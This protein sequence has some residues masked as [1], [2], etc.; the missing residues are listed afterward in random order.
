M[1]NDAYFDSVGIPEG[2][3]E[4]IHLKNSSGNTEINIAFESFLFSADYQR[5]SD[6]LIIRGE[7]GRV[8]IIEGYFSSDHP[9][10]LVGPKGQTLYGDV[11]A[12][13]AGPAN[14]G[15]YAQQGNAAGASP[16]GQVEILTGGATVQRTDGTVEPL[17]V[18]SKVFQNDVVQT[19]DGG[20]ISITF[21]DGTVFSLSSDSR[22]VLSEMVFAPESAN[23][24]AV[25]NLVKGTFVF[26][27]GE[28]AK[29][30][31]MNV[32]TPVATMGIR[33]TTVTVEIQTGSDGQATVR[34]A[35]NRDIDGNIGSI[36]FTNTLDGTVTEITK[37]DSSWIINPSDGATREVERSEAEMALDLVVIN[38]AFD[39]IQS[40]ED[41]VEQGE[42]LVEGDE[43][44]GDTAEDGEENED[45]Q[46]T[47]DADDTGDDDAGDGDAEGDDDGD[48]G[49]GDGDDDG[50]T[51][52]GDDDGETVDG[53]DD[54]DV[55]TSEGEDDG[56]AGDGDSDGDTGDDGNDG[57]DNSQSG[58]ADGDD[59]STGDQSGISGSGNDFTQT[60]TTSTIDAIAGLV[61]TLNDITGGLLSGSGSD[62]VDTDTSDGSDDGLADLAPE[63]NSQDN[64][65][66]DDP[67]VVDTTPTIGLPTLT[68]TV[69]EDG[70]ISL[71]DIS[72]GGFSIGGPPDSAA[73]MTLTA[74]STVS[75]PP[76][77]GL[78]IDTLL[79]TE[80]PPGSGK[81]ETLVVSGTISQL[82]AALNGLV[83]EPSADDDDGGS[84]T[85]FITNGTQAALSTL[86]IGIQP[87]E[88]PPVAMDD[89]PIHSE[90][91]AT[92]SNNT[93]T[94]ITGTLFANDFDPDSGD[95][96]TVV[97]MVEQPS[98]NPVT[99]NVPFALTTGA[100]IVF[101]ADGSYALT[102][103]TAYEALGVGDQQQHQFL[104]TIE[105]S[106]GRQDTATLTLTV[107]GNND[108]PT[109]TGET[110]NTTEDTAVN[111]NLFTNAADPD[112]DT[113]TFS[114]GTD[115]GDAP[116]NGTVVVNAN[117]TFTYTPNANFNG[118]D[119][120]SYDVNDGNGG[121]A[122]ATVTVNVSSVSDA[123]EGSDSTIALN[124]DSSHT[125]T[126]ADFGFSDPGDAPPDTFT[127]VKVATLPAN[128]ALTLNGGAIT[129]NQVITVADVSAGNL[130]FTPD[131]N[132]NGVGYASITF[133]VQ[134][135]GTGQNEDLSPNT[136]TFDVNSVND[137]PVLT[138]P[139]SGSELITNGGFE[140]G[141]EG[142][143]GFTLVTAI[144]SVT[145]PGWT[146]ETGDV[147]LYTENS[148]L[149]APDGDHAIDLNGNAPGSV[150]QT[151]TTES[152]KTYLLTFKQ[153]GDP[154][155]GE[156][157]GDINVTAGNANVNL[158]FTEPAG[159]TRA[160]PG[161][162]TH[163]LV[164]TASS[165]STEV[166]FTSLDTTDP[167]AGP[168]LD[169][170][171][172]REVFAG[173]QGTPLEI[174]NFSVADI[175]AG[176]GDV[177][178]NFAAA[179]GT[180][181]VSGT[182]AGGVA[183]SDITNNETA[184]VTLTGTV[185][186][187]NAT[188]AASGGVSYTSNSG[189]SGLD[190]V[191]VTA[192]DLP[193]AGASAAL[194]DVG[195]VDIFVQALNLVSGTVND[196][197][198]INGT[199]GDDLIQGLG[200]T[201]GSFQGD[202]LF[203]LAGDDTLVGENGGSELFDGGDGDDTIV[204][205]TNNVNNGDYILGSLGNDR[206]VLNNASGGYVSFA[207]GNL[208]ATMISIAATI[209]FNTN[210]ASIVKTD[211]T[212][213]PTVVGTDTIEDIN[214]LISNQG[215]DFRGTQLADTFNITGDPNGYVA[216]LGGRGNDVFNLQ[217]GL[218]RL[219]FRVEASGTNFFSQA[220][221][222]ANVDLRLASNQIINDGFGFTDN[223]IFS[224]NF[225]TGS[226]NR[227][228]IRGT[229]FTDTLIGD[230]AD[231]R[232][233]GEQGNDTIDGQGGVDLIR[234]DRSGAIS[235]IV[236]LDAGTATGFWDNTIFNY[237]ISNLEDVRGTN[238]GVDKIFGSSSG[239]NGGANRL[240]GRGG[241][242]VL[243]GRL[244][245]D[246]LVGGDDHNVFMINQNS[247]NDIIEDFV[248]G[249][250]RIVIVE[251]GLAS[252]ASFATFT[253]N[254]SDTFIS[255]D[256]GNTTITVQGVDLVTR[257]G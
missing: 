119:T 75:L 227:V 70:S 249:L 36:I 38:Q 110:V 223:I 14:P 165:T 107:T 72:S 11:V 121:T 196:D 143:G 231:N 109:A 43:T 241:V 1:R 79:S 161:S 101:Q 65:D 191:T 50:D 46:D 152:G 221:Q 103:G 212:G 47:D 245:N 28:V 3:V 99:L 122:S 16:I 76:G 216:V 222:A 248:I 116:S 135:S 164:F 56:D 253:F 82:N 217:S 89:T 149:T 146:V 69:Q 33:G 144:D 95:T 54:S 171:S 150:S 8:V 104:Y 240:E 42:N 198:A 131:A 94:P 136:L 226:G 35:L 200:T 175:D 256:S 138:V 31:D 21:L 252:T 125:L 18:G 81:Y 254:G 140:T 114:A 189:F 192:N 61:D 237:T 30:G 247:G 162:V 158:S 37:V 169:A 132:D 159:A 168:H 74:G 48:T 91:E 71:A 199:A 53:D 210:T 187:I 239:T 86:T 234:F 211:N 44:D 26:V 257:T 24:S 40:A 195:T 19:E 9:I 80:Q 85:I 156:T 190:T 15:Q 100:T 59:S 145:I 66:Q 238:V 87:V 113:L 105:D 115:A 251:S 153:S 123:P 193:S 178:V 141:P 7:D 160:N 204:P 29:T 244:G 88:D 246:T 172:V 133:Q 154:L 142:P 17:A 236:D 202:Q 68:G 41:R 228:E 111:D 106:T 148:F 128:G 155:D 45:E 102:P 49:D 215:A 90:D 233:I 32:Q 126:L 130:V 5:N 177:T 62:S 93:G 205:G 120:F 232:F 92:V 25:F 255:F 127:G 96:F 194:N 185:A 242:D 250:D 124:E 97:G 176:T 78:V 34:V 207:Y 182:V 170:V 213:S 60:T 167:N 197:G 129:A 180:I 219:E 235:A 27:A 20:S 64:N 139:V 179:N 52:D 22:M 98:S 209:N 181:T 2:E 147:D 183:A 173:V 157:V 83:Y 218:I 186:E 84:L 220:T 206:V 208:S 224:A 58:D 112:G 243:N 4:I 39:A 6:E 225:V 10:D 67:V 117:G 55:D 73:T 51:G 188:L 63:D 203:G 151:I 184:S 77:T 134:D 214:N 174:G 13:L 12:A 230:D 163:Q 108:V 229:D 201:S 57:N 166:A 137:G 23:N 118:S